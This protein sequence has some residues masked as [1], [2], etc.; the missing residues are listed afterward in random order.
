MASIR[1][2]ICRRIQELRKQAGLTQEKLAALSGLS[3]DG[4][5]KIETFRTTPTLET[6][7]KIGKVFQMS[8]SELLKMRG[9]ALLCRP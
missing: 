5:R 4:I 3:V 7:E 2:R 6:L 8:L 1:E 9:V